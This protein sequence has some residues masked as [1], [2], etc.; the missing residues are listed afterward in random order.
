MED[1]YNH[2]NRFL[3]DKFKERT[4]KICIDGS[5]TCPNRD[6]TKGVGGC[7]FCGERGSG[8]NTKCLSIKEQVENYFK[9]YKAD[10]ANKFIVYFQNFTN[11]YDSIENLKRKYDEA[12]IDDRIVAMD[13]ATRADCISE[14]ICKL[15][16]TYKQK[17]YVYCEIGLQTANDDTHNKNNQHITNDDFIKAISLLNKYDIDV[18]CHVM[19]GL[20]GESHED[21]VNTVNLLNSVK[22][23]GIKIHSTYVIKD[24]VLEG[25]YNSHEYEPITIDDYI[26]EVVY[27]LTHINK[28]VIVHRITGD[29][30]KD[31]LIAPS[32]ANHKKIILNSIENRLKNDNLYQGCLFGK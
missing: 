23:S 5:F 28:D 7:I 29:P 12:L 25:M 4:L 20:P 10:R 26:D 24:T 11:T 30:P 21:I 13:I 8:E 1:R 18:V 2:L 19:V 17:Y 22:Y 16:A 32:W 14:D 31:I 27:I 6:G 15:L 3:K 9:S